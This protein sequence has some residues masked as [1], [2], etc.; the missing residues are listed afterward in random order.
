MG[1]LWRGGW[2][3]K[4]RIASGL[5]LFVYVA[6]HFLNIGTALISP[7]LADAFQLALAAIVRSGLGTVVLYGALL[8]HAALS[9]GKIAL[10][11]RLRLSWVDLT[12]VGFGV[13]IPLL[14]ATHVV[15]TRGSAWQLETN[16]TITYI[17]ALIWNTN[18]GWKQ[19]FLLLITWAHGCIGLHMWLRMTVWWR[20]NLPLLAGMATLVP[21]FALAGFMVDGRRINTVIAADEDAALDFYD[22]VNW[23][24]PS[25][26]DLLITQ[27]DILFWTVVGMLSL[28]V[29][30]YLQRHIRRP[31]QTVQITYVDGPTVRSAPGPTLL[32]ISRS[33]GVPHMALCGGKGRCTTC[34]VIVEDGFDDIAPPQKPNNKPC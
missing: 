3:T 27:S 29:I 28:T 4:A 2:T 6:L 31:G 30:L 34:R 24:G 33:S 8:V 17:A 12:Q 20:R 26:F 16:D 25:E 18:D 19:A 9:L 15:F 10:T 5:V 11:V 7:S 22:D 1:A 21:F 23:P 13:L 14:L 32:D